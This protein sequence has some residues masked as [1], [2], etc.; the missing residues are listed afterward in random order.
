VLSSSLPKELIPELSIREAVQSLPTIVQHGSQDQMIEVQRAQDSVE[1]L[2]ALRVPLTYRE[3][4]MGHEITPRGL[5]EL[6]AWLDETVMKT[7]S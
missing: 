2:R 4:D 3:Y 6:S 5:T 1:Q 7:G